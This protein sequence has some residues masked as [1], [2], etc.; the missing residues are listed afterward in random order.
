MKVTNNP[1]YTSSNLFRKGNLVVTK[2]EPTT[3]ILVTGDGLDQSNFAG[4]ELFHSLPAYSTPGVHS[5]HWSR[6]LY[7]QYTGT[8]T[9]EN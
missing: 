7:V 9:L 6:D 1:T 4:T 8:L 2:T 5:T 3:I